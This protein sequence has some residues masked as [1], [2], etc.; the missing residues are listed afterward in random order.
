[1]RPETGITARRV[2]YLEE[3]R[4]LTPE[5]RARRA[6]LTPRRPGRST[7]RPLARRGL[8]RP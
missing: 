7:P 5:E 6:R 1:M 2:K 4:G 3:T 8:G